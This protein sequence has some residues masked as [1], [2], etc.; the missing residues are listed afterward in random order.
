MRHILSLTHI[1]LE[2]L[3]A[4]PRNASKGFTFYGH[5]FEH[6]NHSVPVSRSEQPF[7]EHVQRSGAAACPPLGI[8]FDW[9]SITIAL[10]DAEERGEKER[11][12]HRNVLAAH[13][14]RG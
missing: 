12:C 4:S 2:C 10:R 7:F 3:R 5:N 11:E 6:E 14:R 9:F 13:S 8:V 1:Q